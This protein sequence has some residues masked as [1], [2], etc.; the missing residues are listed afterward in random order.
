MAREKDTRVTDDSPHAVAGVSMQ[1]D[2]S[3]RLYL[4]G[5][6]ELW[7]I[8]LEGRMRRVELPELSSGDAP[9]RIVRRGDR[10]VAWGYDTYLLDPKLKASPTVIVRDSWF[11]IPSAREDRVWIAFVDPESGDSRRIKAVRE[12]TVDGEVTVPDA[13]PPGGS[14]P[15]RAVEDGLVL[16][17]DGDWVV[18]DPRSD[19]VKFRLDAENIGPTH[20]NVLAW[21]DRSCG[22]VHFTDVATGSQNDVYPTDGFGAFDV[23]SAAFSPDGRTLA[24]P[25]RSKA[26][27]GEFDQSVELQL[28]LVDVASG[29]ANV[30][31]GSRVTSGY[32]FVEWASSGEYV[33]FA[34]GRTTE[35]RTIISYRVGDET[36]RQ[37]PVNVGAF[38]G[39]AAI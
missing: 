26:D 18:W 33:F 19:T 17:S 10:L 39:V 29:T 7:M 34:G 36:A 35:D 24:V 37:L 4:A 1:S 28:A 9:Y 38:Y 13:H 30:V 8:D 31:Q 11:F 32:N 14:W 27:V 22:S 3:P 2:R 5:D 25:V 12:V 6:G 16:F 21:C 15:E 23:A 20:G